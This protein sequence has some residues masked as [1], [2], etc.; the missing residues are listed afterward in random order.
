MRS[1]LIFISFS[2]ILFSCSGSY[3][4]TSDEGNFSVVF[5]SKPIEGKHPLNTTDIYTYSYETEDKTVQY[6]VAYNY[7]PGEA[8]IVPDTLFQ[9]LIMGPAMQL[10]PMSIQKDDLQIEGHPGA[11]FKLLGVN[12]ATI[13]DIYLVDRDIYQLAIINHVPRI[14]TDAEI[15]AFMGSFKLLKK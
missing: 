13:Y 8:E 10:Q 5:P 7:M 11:R 4:V 6:Q 1:L 2:I 15:K 3:T 9:D 12:S 14:P